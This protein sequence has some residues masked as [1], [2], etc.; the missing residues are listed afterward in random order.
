MSFRK[1]IDVGLVGE[2]DARRELAAEGWLT[3]NTNTEKGNFPNVDLIAVK[4]NQ[5]RHIQVKTTNGD[6]GSHRDCLFMGRAENWLSKKIPFYNNKKGPFKAHL[7]ILV[8]A[9]RVKSRFVVLPVALAENIAKSQ[10]EAWFS[11][12]K[13]D[14]TKRAAGF[15]ARPGF[16]KIQKPRDRE[17]EIQKEFIDAYVQNAEKI[18]KKFLEFEDRWDLLDLSEENLLDQKIW[19]FA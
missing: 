13:R 3:I 1:E 7:I 18:Q 8:H 9:R 5:V 15:D 17:N 14:G 12:E 4:E 6:L 11:I 2:I 10:A 19:S 16:L